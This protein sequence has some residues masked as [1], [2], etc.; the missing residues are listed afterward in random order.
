MAEKTL[1]AKVHP[2]EKEPDTLLVTCPVVGMADGAPKAGIF[3]N[4]FDQIITMKIL[5]QRYALRLPR[6][7]HGRVTE[8]FIPNS[9]TPVAYGEPIARLDPRALAGGS[10]GPGSATGSAGADDA[11]G[12][13]G[14]ITIKAPSEGI[15]YRRSSPDSPPYVEVGAEITT[16]S[17]LGL[18]EIMKCF[19]QITYGG[20][21]LPERGKVEEILADDAAEVQFGQVLFRIKPL[22]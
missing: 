22:E 18:V 19:N 3:L 11:T 17:V 12:D 10:A 4:A 16:G 8:V 13:A 6:D 5:N 9:Y 7:V 21:G 2:D 14:L 20:P 15:F 1:I